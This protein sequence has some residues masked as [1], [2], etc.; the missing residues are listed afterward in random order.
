MNKIE[1][2][3][4]NNGGVRK[5][6]GRPRLFQDPAVINFKIEEADKVLLK[7]LYGRSL[8]QKFIT[9]VQELIKLK[10]K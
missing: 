6:A 3:R 1:D 4:R 7:Q 5:G 9:W 8:N 10:Q 2:K